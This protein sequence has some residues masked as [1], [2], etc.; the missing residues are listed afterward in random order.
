MRS[1][2]LRAFLMFIPYSASAYGVSL[3][4]SI[5]A[6]RLI[7]MTQNQAFKSELQVAPL[8]VQPVY[9]LKDFNG[10]QESAL[11]LTELYGRIPAIRISVLRRAVLRWDIR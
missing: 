11:L 3:D 5:S 6:P 7:D 9:S 4:S 8:L 1:I 10:R 2:L